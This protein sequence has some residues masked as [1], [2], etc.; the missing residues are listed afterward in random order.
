MGNTTDNLTP[1]PEARPHRRSKRKSWF[2]IVGAVLVLVL[3]GVFARYGL[4]IGEKV[5][6]QAAGHKVYKK[7]IQSLK[8]DNSAITDHQVATVLADKYLT[9]A[10]AKEQ[11]VTVTQTEIQT[12]VK[13]AEYQTDNGYQKTQLN[14]YAYQNLVN[15]LYFTKLAANNEGVYQ[16]KLLVANFSKNVPYQSPL[17]AE[18]KSTNPNLG[19]P[20]AIAQDKQYA[21]TFITNLYDQLQTKKI[22]FDQAIQMEHNDPVVGT[23]GYPTQSHSTSFNGS[24]SQ[25]NLLSADSIRG[26]I[27]SIKPGETTKPFVVRS[28]SSMY[29][30]ST[31][32]SYFLVVRLDKKS[33]GNNSNTSFPQ[34]LSQK[35]QQLGYKVNV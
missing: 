15:Q 35:K 33:G 16:G 18:K 6:A 13:A 28:S 30:K 14:P 10:M 7:E 24:L 8:G 3:V 9:E 2:L 26:K 31:A 29:D 5:Y 22:T 11:N 21:Q 25:N 17:L 19:N 27:T 32:E 34:L 1:P 4:H 12:A 23:K 20:A